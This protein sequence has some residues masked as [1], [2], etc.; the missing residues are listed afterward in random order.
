MEDIVENMNTMYH[1]KTVELQGS[2]FSSLAA[3]L[4]FSYLGVS[5][6]TLILFWFAAPKGAGSGEV[7]ARGAEPTGEGI[8]LLCCTLVQAILCF[9]ARAFILLLTRPTVRGYLY[10]VL[11]RV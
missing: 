1:T 6:R 5:A 11:Y 8:N 7:T 3:A 2:V 4:P 10:F 9:V